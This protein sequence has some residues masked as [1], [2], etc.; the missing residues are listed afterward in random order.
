MAPVVKTIPIFD[1]TL[2]E[3]V[4]P[5]I[6]GRHAAWFPNLG[7]K[8]PFQFGGM[9]T[10]YRHNEALYAPG[11]TIPHELAILRALAAEGMAPPIGNLVFVETLVSDHPGA[12]H[13]DPCGAWGYEMADAAKLPPGRF[14]LAHMRA[15]PIAGSVGAWGDVDKPDNVVN[16]YLVDVRRSA[17]DMLRWTGPDL[18]ILPPSPIEDQEVL[19]ADVHRLCQFPKGER[20]RAYQ[21]FWLGGQWCQG[22]RRIVERATLLGFNPRPGETVLEIGCQ[23]GGFLQLAHLAMGGTGTTLGVEVDGDYVD[24]ARRL[25]RRAGHNICFRLL[26]A[27]AEMDRLVSWTHAHSPRGID[28][29]ITCSMEKHLGEAHLFRLV[30]HLRARTSYIETNAIKGPENLK[31]WPD[32]QRRG[33]KHVGY[34]NDRNLRAL[35]RIDRSM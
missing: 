28:H 6:V 35:Y 16:G 25:A 17:F 30:D 12:W 14:N 32:V 27:N 21:D 29:L 9:V 2:A 19:A 7:V 24:C 1:L 10:K 3:Q 26:D 34:S 33:G 20:Q 13:A 8:V 4:T 22:D 5:S 18:P 11:D 31:L 15:M 23:S